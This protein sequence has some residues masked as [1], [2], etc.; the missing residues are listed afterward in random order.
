VNSIAFSLFA[1]LL[2]GTSFAGDFFGAG[3]KEVVRGAQADIPAAAVALERASGGQY[4]EALSAGP[5]HLAA[6]DASSEGKGYAFSLRKARI[7]QEFP[8]DTLLGFIVDKEKRDIILIG[9]RTGKASYV[10]MDD[11]TQVLKS[12]RRQQVPICSLDPNTTDIY[13]PPSARI[14]GVDLDSHFAKVMLEAD[15]LMKKL[16]QRAV[17]S[18][19]VRAPGEMSC[20]EFEA[21]LEANERKTYFVRYWFTPGDHKEGD[22]LRTQNGSA[23]SIKPRVQVLTSKMAAQTF[24]LA[25]D[26]AA[27][28]ND[29]RFAQ[30]MSENFEELKVEFPIFYELESLYQW[31]NILGVI[32]EYVKDESLLGEVL[33][34][35]ADAQ[36]PSYPE[37]SYPLI[38][39]PQTKHCGD[40]IY[41]AVVGGGVNL[42]YD[43]SSVPVPDAG[44]DALTQRVK[45]ARPE[46]AILWEFDR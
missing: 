38:I 35:W 2:A 30:D 3:W 32:V 44:L 10:D 27:L 8:V 9:K 6:T 46:G 39:D 45:D 43:E 41:S 22:V 14:Q 12:V 4:H 31:A 16:S 40:R 17:Q 1:L 42:G 37:L 21:L 13:A 25:D 5:I 29:Q 20:E 18:R 34:P 11:L 23:F 28:P 7:G 15:Y 19:N 36:S 26:G 24:G 33:L